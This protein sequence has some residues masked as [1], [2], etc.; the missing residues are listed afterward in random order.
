MAVADAYEAMLA[1]R[2][3][4]PALTPE[5]A[6]EELKRCA[7]TQFDPNVVAAFLKISPEKR[8]KIHTASVPQ[9]PD[10]KPQSEKKARAR[11]FS[12]MRASP[13]RVARSSRSKRQ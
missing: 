3:Y 7:G 12:Q 9:L 8:R 5:Q 2:P 4:R 1:D 13:V 6:E 10:I 11:P